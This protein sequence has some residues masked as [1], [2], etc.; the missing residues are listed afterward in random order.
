MQMI[1][2]SLWEEKGEQRGRIPLP[3]PRSH[4]KSPGLR[5]GMRH[6][7]RHP[8]GELPW[9][10]PGTASALDAGPQWLHSSRD[11]WG[12]RSASSHLLRSIL[13][14]SDQKPDQ[15]ENTIL[16]KTPPETLASL[17]S[18]LRRFPVG[19]VVI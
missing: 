2:S 12:G 15:A 4:S 9:V 5:P 18:L 8:D 1:S 16:G 7:A 14:R 3:R 13:A 17:T 19:I 6:S 11:R 10:C